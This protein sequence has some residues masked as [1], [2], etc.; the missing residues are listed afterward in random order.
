MGMLAPGQAWQTERIMMVQKLKQYNFTDLLLPVMLLL[1]GSFHTYI[2]CALSVVMSIYL[3]C[4]LARRKVLVLPKSLWAL[5]IGAVCLGYGASCLW[6]IDPGM[7]LI[8]F[9]K[10]LP[11]GLYALCLWQEEQQGQILVFLPG[12]AAVLTVLSAIGMQIPA[13]SQLFSVA[14]R[15]AGFFQYPNTFA[16]FLLVC[17]LLV[18]KK[19][20]LKLR[21]LLILAVLTGGLLYTGSRTVFVLFL[22]SNAV[23]LL[24]GRQKKT[25]ILLAAAAGGA[26]VLAVALLLIGGEDGVL[27]RYLTISLTESTF[28]GRLLYM[29]DALP[30]L[31]KHPFGMGYMG[32]Y[33]SQSAVQTGV[34][35]VAYVH[36]DFLQ[37]LLDVGLIPGGLL[38]A[39][40]AGFLLR[41]GIPLRDKLPV[42]VLCLHSLFDF[43]FQ[44]IGMLCLL[45]LLTDRPTTKV[46]RLKAGLPAMQ[47][48]AA[49]LAALS[50]YLGAA[51]MLS[52]FRQYDLADTLYP[53]NTQN[54]LSM[55]EQ[56]DDVAQANRIAQEILRQNTT[57]YV[58][59]SIQAKYAYTQGD[60]ASMIQNKR[61]VFQLYPF[62]YEEYEEY[63]VMLINGIAR[64]QQAGDTASVQICQQQLLQAQ[65]ALQ[66]N[67][68]RL[69]PLG[70]LIADQ[71]ITQLSEDV[72][73]YI[74]KMR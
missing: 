45:I 54:K 48:A 3:I 11:V 65:A 38:L 32:Y 9:V 73:Y 1:V 44:F 13:V 15:L 36:N 25:R 56:E 29:V 21:D 47:A 58:P 8:G 12:F 63:C 42:A 62:G 5:A 57:C 35:A 20:A 43:N 66:A 30:L 28:V 49:V 69:S 53:Y 14:G 39:A 46:I 67:T 34:Y 31:L 6:A 68:E 60:F 7:A 41:K 27:Y 50:L 74:E 23:A 10:F 33:Y 72:R 37:I 24:C 40:A 19:P 26:A 55:L 51:T 61:T 18:L 22:A 17:E 4:R 70:R 52:H 64:Y 71:P 59:Y 16:L 2:G